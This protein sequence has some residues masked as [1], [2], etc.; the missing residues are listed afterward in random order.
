MTP[1][2]LAPFTFFGRALIYLSLSLCTTALH[3]AQISV[4][5]KTVTAQTRALSA[6]NY[7]SFEKIEIARFSNGELDDWEEKSFKGSTRYRIR[8]D[9]DKGQVLHAQS[10]AAASAI[11]RR[12]QIDLTKTPYLNWHWIINNRLEGIN[13]AAR[14]GD[15]FAARVYVVKTAG[16]F[17]RNSKALNYVWSSN[18]PQGSVWSNPFKPKNSKMI[19]VRG[20]EHAPGQW[21]SE[22]RNIAED[23]IRLYGT[24]VNLVD[25]VVIM[26]DTDNSGLSASASYGDIFFSSQ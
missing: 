12:V 1:T 22:R 7:K 25:L 21:A 24:K 16:V 26:T 20:I 17:G 2:Q 6:S 13:E 9:D 18:K 11:G 14:S 5:D 19:A 4:R 10:N 8:T 3:A 23:F 15:D